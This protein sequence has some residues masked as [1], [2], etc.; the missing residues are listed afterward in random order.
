M[1]HYPHHP[2]YKATLPIVKIHRKGHPPGHVCKTS[3]FGTLFV[4]KCM[5]YH[6]AAQ[7]CAIAANALVS[8]ESLLQVTEYLDDTERRSELKNKN[9]SVTES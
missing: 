6:E 7:D 3:E 4:P 8:F 2:C 5:T 1:V 9:D